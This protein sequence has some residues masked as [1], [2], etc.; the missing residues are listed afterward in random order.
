MCGMEIR[1]IHC[2][3]RV[4]KPKKKKIANFFQFSSFF[5]FWGLQDEA[6]IIGHCCFQNG[7]K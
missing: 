4:M 5:F 6:N 1:L 2:F 7:K 3:L